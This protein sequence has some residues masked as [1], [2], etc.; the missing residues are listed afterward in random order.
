MDLINIRVIITILATLTAIIFILLTFIFPEY[1]KLILTIEVI[2]L[3]TIYIIGNYYAEN[4]IQKRNEQIIRNITMKAD[5]L[6]KKYINERTYNIK[7]ETALEYIQKN[8]KEKK[9]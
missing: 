9:K 7:L 5:D 1:S 8:G 3:P 6:S 4:I 2:I